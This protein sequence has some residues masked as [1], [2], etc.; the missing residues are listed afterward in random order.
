MKDDF[1]FS[2]QVSAG[3][4]RTADFL[5]R[6]FNSE[7]VEGSERQREEPEPPIKDDK[8]IAKGSRDLIWRAL[9]R[10]GIWNAPVRGHRLA[11]PVRTLLICRVVAGG[12]DKIQLGRSRH[13]KFVPGLMRRLAVGIPADSICLSTSDRS[14]PEGWLP[15]LYAVNRP[16]PLW[17]SPP[18][19]GNMEVTLICHQPAV[20]RQSKFQQYEVRSGV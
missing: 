18:P 5:K 2:T 15:A 17:F 4:L 8:C 9:H 6:L 16:L 14:W 3:E 11:W 10:G 1:S 7:L 12:D 20:C 19:T 13:G